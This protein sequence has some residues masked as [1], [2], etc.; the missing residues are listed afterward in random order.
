MKKTNVKGPSVSDLAPST[1]GKGNCKIFSFSPDFHLLGIEGVI[2]T[3]AT[4]L[5]PSYKLNYGIGCWILCC[6][7]CMRSL[8]YID[9]VCI[10][11]QLDTLGGNAP[12]EQL[13]LAER[14]SRV[15]SFR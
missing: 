8:V 9:F 4:N 7:N 2:R 3:E 11:M 5:A 10:V 6:E 13:G 12:E 1:G 14:G 15:A